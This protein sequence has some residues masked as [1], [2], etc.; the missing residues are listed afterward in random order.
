MVCIYTKPEMGKKKIS[1]CFTDRKGVEYGTHLEKFKKYDRRRKK[2]I[3]EPL[4]TSYIF[5]YI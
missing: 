5:G 3:E 1:K 2:I 4:F